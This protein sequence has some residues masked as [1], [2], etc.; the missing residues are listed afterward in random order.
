ML[1]HISTNWRRSACSA[2]DLLSLEQHRIA[3]HYQ[4]AT[5]NPLLTLELV[6]GC[7][8]RRSL[9][10]VYRE[11]LLHH[12]PLLAALCSA[13]GSHAYNVTL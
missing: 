10:Q 3:D 1:T 7:R 11:P 9:S 8:H 13:S 2:Q 6:H 4:S 12:Q 5:A